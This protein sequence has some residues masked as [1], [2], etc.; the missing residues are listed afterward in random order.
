MTAHEPSPAVQP[1]SRRAI[2]A[3]A[4]TG[5]GAWAASTLTRGNP[6]AAASGDPIRMGQTNSAGGTNTTV[7]TNTTGPAYKVVQNGTGVALRGESTG[8]NAAFLLAKN[9]SKF[10]LF[11]RNS[12]SSGGSGGAIRAVGG[13]N[14]GVLATATN[15]A[16]IVGDANA[17]P[18]VSGSSDSDT[19]VLGTSISGTGVVG[20][21]PT[22]VYGNS[23]SSANQTKG[24]AGVVFAGT[25]S[26]WGVY[27]E[28]G[29][30]SGIGVNGFTGQGTGTTI[31]VYGQSN[32]N[33]GRG[34][35]GYV[36]SASGTT[37]GARGEAVS[38]TGRGVYGY[39]SAASGANR[40][41][42]GESNSAT[43]AGVYGQ[44]FAGG[45]GVYSAGHSAVVGNLDVSGTKNF[46]V[47]HPLDPANRYL[48]HHCT[49]GAEALTLYSGTV[50]LGARGA[51][52]V[53]LPAWFD[54]LNTDV[55][56][57]LTAVGASMPGLY[58]SAKVSGNRFSIAGGVR[59]GE[60]SWQ[61]TARRRGVDGPIEIDKPA[62][63]RG[64]YVNPKLYGRRESASLLRKL[65]ARS[66]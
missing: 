3:G 59:G 22:G 6:V 60:V 23:D 58:V 2:L 11:A 53:S 32:S 10:G 50:K 43:G 62:D 51:A 1:R 8:G 28:S 25:G 21:G 13:Q 17:A 20:S 4:L 44:N 14:I 41:V 39:A 65:A 36:P 31:G 61:L 29:S 26:T 55:R 40:G 46:K 49:E 9:K 16:A 5:I 42:L 18:G 19:G 24:V 52:R 35:Y 66:G 15:V 63:E 12:S 30:T 56:Y 48:L 27:G 37:Y 54:G 45:Y 34:V 47:D 38:T 57:Q 7:Q 64:T 33:A